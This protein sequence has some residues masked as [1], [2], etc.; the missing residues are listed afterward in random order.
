[1]GAVFGGREGGSRA[2]LKELSLS[3]VRKENRWV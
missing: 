3:S 2:V 1:M